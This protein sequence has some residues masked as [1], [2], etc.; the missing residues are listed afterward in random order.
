[1]DAANLQR[2]QTILKCIKSNRQS[3]LIYCLHYAV[4]S[5][6]AYMPTV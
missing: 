1:M 2:F 5:N 4:L 6:Y 3:R